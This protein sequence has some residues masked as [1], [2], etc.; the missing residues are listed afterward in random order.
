MKSLTYRGK[1]L[2]TATAF[3]ILVVVVSYYISDRVDREKTTIIDTNTEMVSRVLPVLQEELTSVITSVWETELMSLDAISRAQ[4]RNV[5]AVL[6]G[7]F[8]DALLHFDRIEGGIYFLNLDAF[9]GYAY[10]AIPSPKPAFG[11]P[12]R[13]YDIIRNQ[14][15]ES[16]FTGRY[17]IDLHGFDPAVFPLG[18]IPVFRDGEAIAAIWA[19]THIE[20]E[21]AATGDVTT[22]LIYMTLVV[23]L[24]GFLI[25]L[26]VS[27]NTSAQIESIRVGL[28]RIKRDNTYRLPEPRGVPGTISHYIN[29]LVSALLAE[30]EKSRSLERDLHQRDKMATLGNLIAGVAHEINTPVAIIKT[31]IQM[32][33]RAMRR[34][35]DAVRNGPLEP[36]SLGLVDHELNRISGL[37]KRLLV[38]SKPVSSTLKPVDVSL[39]L[40]EIAGTLNETLPGNVISEPTEAS[41]QVMGDP[42][43]L[44]QVFINLIRNGLEAGSEQPEVRVNVTGQNGQVLVHVDDNGVGI[45]DEHIHRIFDPFFTTKEDG[46]GL[47][48]AIS[49]EIIQAHKG[50]LSFHRLDGSG[51]RCTV[52]LPG[53]A[54]LSPDMSTSNLYSHEH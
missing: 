7:A 6:S 30:Q 14:S 33:Q 31:R 9:I 11:P 24:L 13:S 3:A 51:T 48:L 5:D 10:P 29:D 2:L 18:T 37:V 41:Y 54:T 49:R 38:F 12:P 50:R 15:R 34:Q 4:E 20:R 22:A 52:E 25:A 19:R 28:D 23:S 42:N 53:S 47:G 16:I 36:D 1:A 27:W 21:L 45:D 46:T 26:A 40:H 44:E 8:E 17:L 39:L 43:T 35:P 32:W